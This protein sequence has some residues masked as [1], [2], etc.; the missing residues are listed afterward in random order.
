MLDVRHFKAQD[1]QGLSPDELAAAAEQMLQ[2]IAEQSKQLADVFV[3]LVELPT[4][5]S[6]ALEHLLGRSGQC[7]GAQTAQV[8][9]F[10]VARVE[11]VRSV[12][13]PTR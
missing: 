1:L 6:D 4:L 11:H 10:E 2:R 9:G 8:L 13:R 5:L 12:P 7:I 3:T